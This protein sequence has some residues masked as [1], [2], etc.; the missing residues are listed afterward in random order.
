MELSVIVR[1]MD[2]ASATLNVL[3]VGAEDGRKTTTLMELKNRKNKKLSKNI[4]SC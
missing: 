4:K 1:L 2:T 3:M